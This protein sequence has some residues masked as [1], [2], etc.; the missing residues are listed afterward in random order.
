MSLYW[1]CTILGIMLISFSL[2]TLDKSKEVDYPLTIISGLVIGL[3][4]LIYGILSRC[5]GISIPTPSV[6]Y[7]LFIVGLYPAW[8][9]INDTIKDY[10]FLKVEKQIQKQ[11]EKCLKEQ[12]REEKL[13]KIITNSKIKLYL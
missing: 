10:K 13:N 3:S 4:S 7:I 2:V 12:Q 11:R 6:L 1:F 9:V 8:P 5:I